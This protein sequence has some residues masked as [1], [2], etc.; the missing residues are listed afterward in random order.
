ML[1]LYFTSHLFVTCFVLYSIAAL[2]GGR[3]ADVSIS[4]ASEHF[5][6]IGFSELKK[7]DF[8]N[9]REHQTEENTLYGKAQKQVGCFS[10]FS[11]PIH[12]FLYFLLLIN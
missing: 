9:N 6:S 1:K 4:T 7:E 5:R 8:G 11:F 12:C 10:S 3:K 2:L